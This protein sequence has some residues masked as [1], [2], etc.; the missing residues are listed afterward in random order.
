MLIRRRNLYCIFVLFIELAVALFLYLL[1]DRG[2]TVDMMRKIGLAAWICFIISGVTIYQLERKVSAFFCFLCFA[3]LFSFGQS[4]MSLFNLQL[5]NTVF[6]VSRGFFSNAIL[7]S[8]AAFV[9]ISIVVTCIGYCLIYEP[10]DIE[11]SNIMDTTEADCRSERLRTVAWILFFIS[12][13]PTFYLLVKDF[14]TVLSIGY[15]ATLEATTGLDRLFTLISGFFVSSILLLYMFEKKK[16]LLVYIIIISYLAM[17]LMGGSRIVIFRLAIVFLLIGQFYFHSLNKRKWILIVILSVAATLVL[18]LVSS[19]R[20][21]LYLAADI[22]QLITTSLQNL[23]KNNFI[24]ASINE[25]GN[26]QLINALV[27]DKCPSVEPFQL[28]FSYIKMLWAIIPN[29]I[30]DAYT[31]YIG[32]DITFS[33]YYTLTNAGMGASYISEG[34]WNFGYL[35]LI[36]FLFFGMLLAWVVKKFEYYANTKDS[37]I[38]L[39][40]TVYVLYFVLFLV[41]SESLEFGR[42]FVY[43]AIV[44]VILSLIRIKKSVSR[45]LS[46]DI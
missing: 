16:R 8:S 46:T 29:F 43:Y 3:Y 17:Q 38:K 15:G 12:V 37:P 30:G 19:I 4:L 31:G 32:I 23:L 10:I 26:T 25:M 42:S 7:K 44:P 9:L 36:A 24:A 39:Y 40:L 2:D 20:N 6:S 22:H 35:S 5:Q 45:S 13:V 27:M 18:S 41:R 21:Y 34:Y 11:S 1:P 33:P 14:K 28:G